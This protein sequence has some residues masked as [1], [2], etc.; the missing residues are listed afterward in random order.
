MASNFIVHLVLE[1]FQ[2]GGLQDGS[3]DHED[4]STLGSVLGPPMYGN[5][6]MLRNTGAIYNTTVG[7]L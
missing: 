6:H 1:Q 3:S 4:H 2:I 5:P 7:G